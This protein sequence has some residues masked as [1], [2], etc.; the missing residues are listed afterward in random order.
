MSDP[1]ATP[2][3]G[4]RG[5]GFDG[6]ARDGFIGRRMPRT[7]A[8]AAHVTAAAW[9]TFVLGVLLVRVW[10]EGF[11]SAAGFVAWLLFLLVLGPIVAAVIFGAL[12]VAAAG[13]AVTIPLAASW[14]RTPDREGTGGF[15]LAHVTVAALAGGFV[16]VRILA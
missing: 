4:A 7:L 2:P 16:L 9:W 1:W 14:L 6:P 12:A 15:A 8:A 13:L 11:D 5:G 3:D 10:L